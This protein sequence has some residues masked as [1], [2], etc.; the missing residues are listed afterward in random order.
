MNPSVFRD[1]TRRGLVVCYGRFDKSVRV[2]FKSHTVV[3]DCLIIEDGTDICPET[4]ITN[5][6]PRT[7]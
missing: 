4:T 2:I 3:F 5:Y 6:Q 7:I 1:V